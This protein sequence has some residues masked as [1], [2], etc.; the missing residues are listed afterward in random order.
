MLAIFLYHHQRKGSNR[1][2]LITVVYE[3]GH[4]DKKIN[5]KRHERK[6][7][8]NIKGKIKKVKKEEEK[9]SRQEGILCT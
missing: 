9:A 2:V 3:K 5:E 1:F 6:E 4:E 7:K 8:K